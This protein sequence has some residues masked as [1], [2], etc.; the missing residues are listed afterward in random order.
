ML[1]EK[2][3]ESTQ[4]KLAKVILAL[5][6][7]PFALWGVESYVSSSGGTDVIASV[8]GQKISAAEY[9][10]VLRDQQDRLRSMLGANYD[11]AMADS[12][13]FRR[14]VLDGI[15]AQRILVD[16]AVRSG[17]TITDQ[18][19]AQKILAVEAF[20][21]SGKFSQTRYEEAL[22]QRGLSQIGFEARMREDLLA[23]SMRA[24]V[25]DSPFVVGSELDAFIKLYEQSR[26]ISVVQMRPEQYLTEVKAGSKVVRDYYDKHTQEFTL[27]EQVRVEY[28]MLSA[29]ELAQTTT[30]SDA[31]IKK[32]YDEH[33]AQ[34]VQQQ[35]RQASH[36]LITVA[37]DASEAT[38]KEALKQ[39]GNIFNQV[40]EHPE[41]FAA[42]AE[43]Y[44]QD[45]GSAKQGGDLGF[46]ARGAMAKPFEDAAFQMTKG[47]IRGPVESEF[48]YHIIKLTEIKGEKVRSLEETSAEIVT[49]LKRQQAS[50]KFAEMAETFGNLVY[51]QSGSLKP[52]ADQLKLAIMQGPWV[53]KQAGGAAPFNNQKLIQA[54]F[55]DEV[56]KNK[57]NT[58]AIEVAPNL[59][60]SARL[61]EHKPATVKPFDQ[62]QADIEQTLRREEAAKIVAKRGREMLEQL[63]QGK[64][65]QDIVWS[66]PKVV[67]RL[68]PGDL[69]KPVLEG[70]F[71]AS[72]AKLPAFMGVEAPGG[73]YTLV[74]ISRVIEAA[75]ADDAKR[76]KYADQI[77]QVRSQAELL[78]FV[79][80]LR[81]TADVKV[82]KDVLE[83]KER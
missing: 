17:V 68:Q 81:E 10:Q 2:L 39:A 47:E 13:G 4:T 30:V 35:E 49:E 83:K 54:I 12:P 42:L 63:K 5:I 20:H 76:R 67:N 26:E 60:V 78:A 21:D 36:I 19:L 32:Y 64:Q 14:E 59:L 15:I 18:T 65:I 40:K 58:E 1:L 62:V 41:K 31:E 16:A 7:I 48:G 70:V 25:M 37:P 73:G 55:S 33:A 22:R 77:Q 61:L 69:P 74:K 27:P 50:K 57:R 28:L 29:A 82:G 34:L 8:G 44:S 71:K 9:N 6:I 3:R 24:T 72:V 56:T 75:A 38:K 79:A 45:P 11:P 53:S 66:E 23:D 46:F 43:Q 52:A 51:E 80:S